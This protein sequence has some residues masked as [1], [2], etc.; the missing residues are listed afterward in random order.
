MQLNDAVP[1]RRNLIVFCM[2]TITFF[3]GGGSLDGNLKLPLFGITLTKGENLVY[4][5][6]MTLCYLVIRYW[7]VFRVAP[8]SDEKKYWYQKANW[9]SALKALYKEHLNS[10]VF[11]WLLNWGVGENTNMA[12]FKDKISEVAFEE[13]IVNTRFTFTHS[14]GDSSTAHIQLYA[15]FSTGGGINNSFLRST[16]INPTNAKFWPITFFTIVVTMFFDKYCS[17][18][19]G[20]WLLLLAS[21]GCCFWFS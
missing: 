3:V 14:E 20:P 8:Y 9:Q 17:D 11:Q 21:L 10:R 1:E 6:W 4:L 13:P 2:A 15:R 19:Y 16:E 18:W 7:L 5:Y 12:P